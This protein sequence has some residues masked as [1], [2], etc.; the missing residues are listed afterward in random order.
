MNAQ[1]RQLAG[2][3]WSTGILSLVVAVDFSLGHEILL[4]LF[5]LVPV[6]LAAWYVGRTAGWIYA[7]L[8]AAAWFVEDLQGGHVYR[9]EFIRY[10]NL[11]MFL[12]CYASV[13]YLLARL[14]ENQDRSLALL[15]EKEAAL[16][17]LES[18]DSKMRQLEGSLQT[19]CAWTNKIKDGDEWVDFP[20][21]MERHLKIRLSHG[22]SPAGLQ[23]YRVA[24]RRDRKVNVEETPREG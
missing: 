23:K 12:G 10:W 19:V 17:A 7:F 18:S 13:G 20:V 15:K 21:F 16:R 3:L 22:M 9:H 5:Y 1:S 24:E 6:G 11:G 2:I 14:R 4:P 8:S